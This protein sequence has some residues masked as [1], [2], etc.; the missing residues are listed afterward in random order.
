MKERFIF[1]DRDGTICEDSDYL[2]DYRV[3]KFYPFAVDAVKIM[4]EKG[5][6]VVIITNQSGVAR[7]KFGIEEAVN[8][9][10]HLLNYL[11]SNGAEIEGYFFCPHHVE[12]TVKEFATECNCRKPETGLINQAVEK[13]DVDWK[14]SYVAGDKLIDADIAKKL[15]AK[16][17]LVLTGY[18]REELK[19]ASDKH[20]DVFENILDF[21]K[22][23]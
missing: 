22:K 20:F 11:K 3:M 1:L 21:A 15:G 5:F 16:G 14:N 10:S 17:V 18:G 6:I 2:D 12:G 7:G 23:L 19:K 13:R 8:Q 9:K 4:K